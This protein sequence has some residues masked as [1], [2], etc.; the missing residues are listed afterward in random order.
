MYFAKFYYRARLFASYSLKDKR[1]IRMSIL[2]KLERDFKLSAIE[3]EDQDLINSLI[4]ACAR[5][6]LDR[7]SNRRNF[8][9]IRAFMEE[10]YEL[11]IYEAF[12]EEF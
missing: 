4:I 7:E 3:A 2:D 9:K 5:V 11:E 8:E 6:S 12:Y 10:Y 1:K